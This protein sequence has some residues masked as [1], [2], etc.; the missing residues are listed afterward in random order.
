MRVS[1]PLKSLP[2][3][4]EPTSDGTAYDLP[5]LPWLRAFEAAARH[6]SFTAAA[7]ELN[8]T[9]AAVSHQVRSLEKYLG[10]TLFERLARTLRLT[11]IGTAYLPP[12][13]RSFDDMA[14]ATAGLFGPVGLR[15]L[16]IRAPVS[17]VSLWLASRVNRFTDAYPTIALRIVSSVWSHAPAEAGTD[18][19]IRFGDGVWPGHHAELIGNFPA[20]ALC[21][22]DRLPAGSQAERLKALSQ[23]PL[24]HVTGYEDLWQRLFRPAGILLAPYTGL[25]IDTTIGALEMA[26]SGFGATMV[27]TCFAEPY[28][29]SGRLVRALDAEVPLE[30]SHYILTSVGAQ[31]Q[32]PEAT[33]FRN[34]I[35]DEAARDE[36][37][38]EAAT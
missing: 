32:H 18:I 15:T 33:L 19:D 23:T 36:A 30:A 37:A 8:L 4:A 11:E 16:V 26:A 14:A 35:R 34:W 12:L 21:R 9:Q 31:K 2:V 1:K 20:V 3:T 13:R 17:F 27:Q 29:A 10:V 28:I 5:P 7:L 24:I 6:Q 25:N 22:P 38:R